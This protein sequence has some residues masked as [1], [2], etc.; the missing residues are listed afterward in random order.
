MDVVC[1]LTAFMVTEISQKQKSSQQQ[2]TGNIPWNKLKWKRVSFGT[3]GYQLSNNLIREFYHLFKDFSLILF[4]YFL[5]LNYFNHFNNTFR[6]S[7][8]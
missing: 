2:S 7:I 4:M 3:K 5:F 6:F 8:F 1:G